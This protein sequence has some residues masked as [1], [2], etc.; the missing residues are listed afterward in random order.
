[1]NSERVNHFCDNPRCDMASENMVPNLSIV[2]AAGWLV[3]DMKM[4][5]VVARDL[6]VTVDDN[7]AIIKSLP[8]IDAPSTPVRIARNHSQVSME[9]V[10]ELPDPVDMERR[11]LIKATLLD[12]VLRLVLPIMKTR[13]IENQLHRNDA[14]I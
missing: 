7:V 6:D 14:I 12:D 5:N 13:Q 9:R 11:D 1:M 8:R 10:I 3:I 4:S 2:K